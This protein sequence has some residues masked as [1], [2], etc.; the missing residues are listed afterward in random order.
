MGVPAE[1][2]KAAMPATSHAG[3]LALNSRSSSKVTE[4]GAVSSN[5]HHN[6]DK[7]G[8]NSSNGSKAGS[9]PGTGA[10]A[11]SLGAAGSS[12][13]VFGTVKSWG[14]GVLVSLDLLR[15]P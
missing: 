13:G 8:G 12:L 2:S 14:E 10:A 9:K 5:S 7:T 3:L 11:D 4:A 6:D 1:S 15:C